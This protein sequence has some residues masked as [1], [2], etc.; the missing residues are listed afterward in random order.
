MLPTLPEVSSANHPSSE[1]AEWVHGARDQQTPNARC[2][3]SSESQ[4]VDSWKWFLI[5]FW[6]QFQL[7]ERSE[8]VKLFHALVVYTWTRLTICL[9]IVAVIVCWSIYSVKFVINVLNGPLAVCRSQNSW[10]DIPG[11]VEGIRRCVPSGKCMNGHQVNCMKTAHSKIFEWNGCHLSGSRC[12]RTVNFSFFHW[13]KQFGKF[14]RCWEKAL[15]LI[16]L[17]SIWT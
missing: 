12:W 10:L 15:E 8:H 17:G 13:D 5:L 3:L 14:I 16:C 2:P 7:A 11:E 9:A 1:V 4:F 6:T